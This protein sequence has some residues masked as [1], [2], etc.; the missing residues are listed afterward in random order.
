MSTIGTL[1]NESAEADAW[2]AD[3]LSSDT[4][5]M[6]MA[7]GVFSTFYGYGDDRLPLIRFTQID[8]DDTMVLNANRIW[9]VLGYQVE[10]VTKGKD[11]HATVRALAQRVDELL[12]RLQGES[13]DTIFVQEVFRRRPLFWRSNESGSEYLHAGGEYEFRVS[14]L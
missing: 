2:L 12:H 9:S 8:S 1:L 6:G 3:Y 11:S 4:E 10:A 13:S 5:L 7:T 14:A